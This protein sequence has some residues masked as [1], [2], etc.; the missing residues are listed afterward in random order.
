MLSDL[1]MET[2]CEVSAEKSSIPITTKLK[3]SNGSDRLENVT[4]GS[5]N[6]DSCTCHCGFQNRLEQIEI[7]MNDLK[8]WKAER[9]QLDDILSQWKEEVGNWM[10]TT[11]GTFIKQCISS[12]IDNRNNN[13][14]H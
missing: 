7:E 9:Q 1:E 4:S 13:F 14:F 12:T 8:S 6:S 2:T 11:F 10:Q 3:V 5:P